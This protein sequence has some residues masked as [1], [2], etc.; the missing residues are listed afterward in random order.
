MTAQLSKLRLC[1][2]SGPRGAGRPHIPMA[3]SSSGGPSYRS[4][5]RYFW[6]VTGEGRWMVIICSRASPAGSQRRI[7]AWSR[8]YEGEMLARDQNE[9]QHKQLQERGTPGRASP[10]TFRSGLPSLSLS[11]LSNLMSS[12]SIS[13]A[14]SSFLKFMIASN[15]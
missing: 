5:Q 11:S 10:L 8:G 3:A 7:T 4:S 15:T 6:A 9:N 12:F 14:V 1:P 13:F 2:A